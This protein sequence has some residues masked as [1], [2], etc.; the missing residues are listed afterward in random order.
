MK[1]RRHHYIWRKYLRAWAINE[2]V[3]CRNEDNIFNSNLMNIGQIKDFY[4]LKEINPRDIEIINKIAIEPT[5]PGL[6]EIN[7]RWLLLFNSVFQLKHDLEQRG[8]NNN[9]TDKLLDE[10]IQNAEEDLHENIESN[11]I[12]YIES[13]L[14][15]DLN[16]FK[17][18]QG[19]M[20]FMHFLC[21][22]YM[23]T[24][25]IKS[26]IL[27]NVAQSKSIEVEVIERIWNILSH[28]YATNMGKVFYE[29]RHSHHIF[30]LKNETQKEFITGD[31]PV[32]NTYFTGNVNKELPKEVEFYYPLSPKLA[33]LITKIIYDLLSD[34]ILLN[35]DEVDKY[36]L[37][38]IEQSHSQIYASSGKV[39]NDIS[40]LIEKAKHNKVIQ[41]DRGLRPGC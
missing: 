27:N 8:L 37:M 39:L 14:N 38:I 6:Q 20:D 24:N 40:S 26:N 4:K 16:F 41:A 5:P 33:I 18:E 22:Q 10:F 36:N 28:I 12:V 29:E 15:E 13:M 19:Y 30:L 7:K 11:A 23:R 34:K 35:E 17:T 21:V 25:K 2:L 3:W 32:I 9:Q 1:K 31:Q